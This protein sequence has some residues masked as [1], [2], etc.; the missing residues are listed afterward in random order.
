MILLE[1]TLGCT[2][3][4]RLIACLHGDFQ[5][6]LIKSLESGTSQYMLGNDPQPLDTA[7]I[8]GPERSTGLR[9]GPNRSTKSNIT[10]QVHV[11]IQRIHRRHELLRDERSECAHAV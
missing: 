5:G 7:R 6:L 8:V 10:V 4:L 1:D 3:S 2:S 11:M 9:G